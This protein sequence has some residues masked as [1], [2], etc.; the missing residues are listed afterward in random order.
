MIVKRDKEYLF[1]VIG[2][3]VCL[4]GTGCVYCFGMKVTIAVVLAV[5]LPVILL[6]LSYV[7]AYGRTF[8]LTPEGIV[9]RFWWF[10]KTYPWKK[11]KTKR[12]VNFHKC[13][14]L[15][16]NRT[17]PYKQYVVFSTRRVRNPRWLHPVYYNCLHPWLFVYINL[18]NPETKTGRERRSNEYTRRGRHYEINEKKFR[19]KMKLWHIVLEE[20]SAD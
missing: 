7:V 8:I 4:I 19:E 18:D 16:I 5:H 6:Y 11:I 2:I 12:V 3:L 14:V 9:I 1:Q 20:G 10:E 15:P 13:P 17:Y